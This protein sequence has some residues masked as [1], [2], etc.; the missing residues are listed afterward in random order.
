[1]VALRIMLAWLLVLGGSPVFAQTT[2]D[3]QALI[4]EWSGLATQISSRGAGSRGPYTLSI[5]RVEG[6]KV[7]GW[8][9]RPGGGQSTSFVGALRGN[10]LTFYTGRFATDLTVAGTRMYGVRRGGG[11]GE[12]TELGLD[13]VV[14]IDKK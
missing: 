12:N 7:Y 5:E 4:G 2:S 9:S 3:P 11:E 10:T 1:M 13:K 8:T 14:V 6:V